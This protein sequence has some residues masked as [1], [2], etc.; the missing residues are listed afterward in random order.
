MSASDT[1]RTRDCP[2]GSLL[3]SCEICELREELTAALADPLIR[4]EIENAALER[5]AKVLE[6]W[7]SELLY[8][9][10]GAAAIRALKK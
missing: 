5:A 9:E 10:D 2:H 1:P 4:G 8:Y 7:Q 3:R 6:N